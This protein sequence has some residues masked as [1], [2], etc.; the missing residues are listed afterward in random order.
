[1]LVSAG[2]GRYMLVNVSDFRRR[3]CNSP[4][5]LELPEANRVILSKGCPHSETNECQ[6]SSLVRLRK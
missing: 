3:L 4:A 1:M 5:N 2:S 6:N